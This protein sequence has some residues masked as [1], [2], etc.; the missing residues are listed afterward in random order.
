MALSLL[1]FLQGIDPTF[2]PKHTKI[3]LATRSVAM[4]RSAMDLYQS[5]IFPSWQ[6]W[7]NNDNFKR[8]YVVS[9]IKI[10]SERTK[11]LF[12]GV[13]FVRGMRG[14]L[15]KESGRVECLYDMPECLQ[16]SHLIGQITIDYHKTFRHCYP[17][18]ETRIDKMLVN[19]L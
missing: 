14:E 9:L 18:A 6:A 7:Q 11:W 1:H 4:A 3:H 19:T 5:G 2:D 13:Y 8:K 16:Y 17:N 12:A 10:P 15:R